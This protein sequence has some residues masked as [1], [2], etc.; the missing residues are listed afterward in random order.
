MRSS[1]ARGSRRSTRS[2]ILSAAALRS[3]AGRSIVAPFERRLDRPSDAA[4]ARID[5]Q[6]P[7][8]VAA[9]MVEERQLVFRAHPLQ[10]GVA[11]PVD[12]HAALLARH[13]QLERSAERFGG[14]VGR[15]RIVL[16]E[17]RAC[18]SSRSAR[19]TPGEPN[20]VRREP[21]LAVD[22]DAAHVAQ[23]QIELEREPSVACRPS[24]PAAT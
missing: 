3:G 13:L 18:R 2:A 24:R 19:G 11:R 16:G 7:I 9:D 12:A 22:L 5:G 4:V 8:R 14:D 10:I 23:R 15:A 17:Q 21:V 1:V 6:L 20:A